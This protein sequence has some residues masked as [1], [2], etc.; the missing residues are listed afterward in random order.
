GGRRVRPPRRG[1]APLPGDDRRSRGGA[2]LDRRDDPRDQSGKGGTMRY[3]PFAPISHLPG[4]STSPPPL[5]NDGQLARRFVPLIRLA[6]RPRELCAVSRWCTSSPATECL[7]EGRQITK[8]H[9][10]G[11]SIQLE[12]RIGEQRLDEF[13]EHG[14]LN[15]TERRP[16]AFKSALHA[17]LAHP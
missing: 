10:V 7:R 16:F 4:V 9:A 2:W 11:D 5:R 1:P 13:P 6:P 12:C 17:S 3:L 8:A 14:F 15:P